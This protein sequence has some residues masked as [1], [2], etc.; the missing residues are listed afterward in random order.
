MENI[1][2]IEIEHRIFTIRGV[3]GLI[4]KDLAELYQVGTKVLNQSVKRNMDR[5][6]AQFRFQLYRTG[7][8]HAF[9]SVKKRNGCIIE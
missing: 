3:Q 4:D 5:F 2:L 1:E 8:G 9:G 6:P 7:C